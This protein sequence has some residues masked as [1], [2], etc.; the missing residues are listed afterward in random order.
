MDSDLTLQCLVHDL[1]NVFQ[2]LVEAGELLSHDQ[3][4]APLGATILRSVERGKAIVGSLNAHPTVLPFETILANAQHFIED[5]LGPGRLTFECEVEA[6]LCLRGTWGW[7]RVLINLFLNAAQAMPQG[8]T[9]R[10]RARRLT[11]A[12]EAPGEIEISIEDC[13]PGISADLLPEIF[14]PRVSTKLQP[15]G[16][17]LH[18]V[19]TIVRQND[20]TV[21]ASNRLD[22]GGASF[23]IRVP[24]AQ[25][26]GHVHA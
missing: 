12:V 20:G 14:K 24:E 19:Q 5:L 2:T 15:S 4:W 3:Q 21:T 10:V 11:G 9:V 7:E 25:Q 13:G 8:G 18:I 17:G 23:I 1:N 26:T 22:R 6:G 16:L